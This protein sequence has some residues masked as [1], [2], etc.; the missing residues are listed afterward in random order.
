ISE[1]NDLMKCQ[2][3]RTDEFYWRE[4]L[5]TLE[6]ILAK[7]RL[8]L[9]AMLFVLVPGLA[10]AQLGSGHT[11]QPVGN[12][13]SAS[14]LP[15]GQVLTPMAAPGSTVQFLS[16]GLREDGNADAAQAVNTALSPDGKTLLVLT[17]GWNNGNRSL[18]GTPITFPTLNPITGGAV[19]STNKS[20]WV[21]VYTI[22][23][24]GTATKQ[25]QI[26][27]PSSYS[28][29]TWAPDGNRFYVSGGQD[30]RVY[31]YMSNGS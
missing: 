8:L 31:I 23:S 13:G 26:N 15:T 1:A 25:Q 20:E 4:S 5:R 6:G 11:T 10:L 21:F 28:G 14:I 18:E 27:V 22:N 30:D 9:K 16:T 29:L 12:F 3:N 2:Q 24:D 7:R 17:S 19:G